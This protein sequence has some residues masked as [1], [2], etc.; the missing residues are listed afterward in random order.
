AG[1]HRL[2]LL[3][4]ACQPPPDRSRSRP[5]EVA[6]PH[7]SDGGRAH[8]PLLVTGRAAPL[9]DPFT[10]LGAANATRPAAQT[11]AP[12]GSG[13]TTLPWGATHPWTPDENGSNGSLERRDSA[14]GAT[15]PTPNRTT[16]RGY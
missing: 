6:P 12:G 13:M 14:V 1:R 2:Q 5:S 4:A 3:L 9:P 15:L 7:P 10:P 8:R 16:A 11:S